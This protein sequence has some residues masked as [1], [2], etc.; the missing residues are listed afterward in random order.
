MLA[1]HPRAHLLITVK[2]IKDPVTIGEAATQ[3]SSCLIL[4]HAP[5]QNHLLL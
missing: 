2:H 4:I 3:I 5:N 1:R